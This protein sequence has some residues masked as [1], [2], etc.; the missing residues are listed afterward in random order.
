LQ[1]STNY[2]LKKE[3]I[4]KYRVNREIR[5]N[6]VRVIIGRKDSDS[7]LLDVRDAIKLAEEQGLDL[8]EVAPNHNPPV[9]RILD[10]GKF[11]FIQ[12]KKAKEAKKSQSKILM[13]D[14]RLRMRIGDHDMKAKQKRI[15][16][17]ITSGF[18]VRIAV[19]FRG[20]E[21]AYPDLAVNLLKKVA[22]EL[23]DISIIDKAPSIEG[24]SL[25]IVLAPMGKV[26]G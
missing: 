10:Y 7:Q 8:V 2:R 11:K 9:C 6:S 25:S 4:K 23:Q 15:R 13:K 18:K 20:R 14:V 16:F 5:S 26:K 19:F 1:R 12:S 17:F 24:R 22:E 21:M 3:N